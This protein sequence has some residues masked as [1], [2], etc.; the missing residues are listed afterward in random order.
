MFRFRKQFAEMTGYTGPGV[1]RSGGG[2]QVFSQELRE[3]IGQYAGLHGVEAT[4]LFG[5][6]C[7]LKPLCFTLF[8]DKVES[9]KN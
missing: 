3:E 8:M 1:T 5:V 9:K 6:S 7:I 2:G 4:V